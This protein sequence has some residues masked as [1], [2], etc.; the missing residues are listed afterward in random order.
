VYGSGTL[1]R[2]H[3]LAK[4]PVYTILVKNRRVNALLTPKPGSHKVY[5]SIFV[6]EGQVD[7]AQANSLLRDY[8]KMNVRVR[9]SRKK[10]AEAFRGKINDYVYRKGN[11]NLPQTWPLTRK[12]VLHGPWPVLST[13]ACLV[14]LPGVRD[15]NAARAK[16]SEHYLQNCSQILVVAPIKRAVDDGTAKELLGEQFKRRLLM[17]GQ[18]GNVSFICTQ[19]DDCEATET[20]RDHQDVAMKKP[21]R[22]EAMTEIS[23]R[24]GSLDRELADLVQ[25]EEDLKAEWEEATQRA[26]ESEEELEEAKEKA[27]ESLDDNE[28]CVVMDVDLLEGLQI[29]FDQKRADTS[30]AL[31]V[32]DS[33]REGNK[34]KMQKMAE[35][36]REMQRELKAMCAIV[37]NEYSTACLQ[38]D[39][40]A[41]LK[42]LTRRPDEE[43]ADTSDTGS[44]P[45]PDD[46]EMDVYCIS[47]NDHLKIQGIK[48]SSDG[49]PSCFTKPEDT[50][51]P[52][53]R[54]FVHET[55]AKHRVSFTEAFVNDASD[56]LDRVK[57]VAAD[58]K[59][60]PSGRSSRRCKAIFEAE[61]QGLEHK[62]QPVVAEFRRKAQAKVQL[63]LQPLLK[64]GAAKGNAAAMTT[65]MS[66]GSLSRRS[67]QDRRP[68][69]NGLSY[70]TYYAT[71]R[72]NGAYVSKAVGE[73]D[74]NQE[75]CDPM[76]KEFSADW[77]RIMDAAFR[78]YLNECE[79][80]MLAIC[81][82]VDQALVAG[83]SGAGMSSDRLSSMVNAAN[84][85]CS[86]SLKAS[87]QAMQTIAAD[88]QRNLNRSLLPM[89]QERMKDGFA[90][91]VN[92]S[93][94][95]RK[96]KRMKGAMEKHAQ[97]AV[98]SMFS[99]STVELL[100]NVGSL[101]EQ[102]ASMAS[103]TDK[104][105]TRTLESVY[106][107]CWDDES[108]TAAL[109]DLVLQETV[110]ACRD[111][112][113]PDLH[114][115]GETVTGAMQLLGIERDELELDVMG[116]ESWEAQNAKK[117]KEAM[118]KGDVIDLMD[119]D[120]DDM[121]TTKS[122]AVGKPALVS[123]AKK[124]KAEPS[125]PYVRASIYARMPPVT[126]YERFSL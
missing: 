95:P 30:L 48:P 125:N 85:S 41:G 60:I 107:V 101:I 14:D 110:R 108:D 93:G 72:Q 54:T 78:G 26:N 69:K 37:R 44:P 98:Q 9:R 119:S 13:G 86:N 23:D 31:L 64:S 73:I 104:V 81:A 10:W 12:V 24:L 34:E 49:P 21:G 2:C 120:D 55:T 113:L 11:G 76:E 5:N 29:T 126:P 52:A 51:I 46:F 80:Q 88:S 103:A 122:A 17:D 77:Q 99:E 117:L 33:W 56:M 18:Y 40:R 35:Q 96:F 90:A 61:M 82:S 74:M 115:L 71:V 58:T 66:W 70:S 59:D 87:F 102:L 38:E 106:S 53:L 8:G 15:A 28:D 6:S 16:V 45:I 105:I 7:P 112:C 43:D 36:S 22:W 50:Q 94:G 20:M 123:T 39:F 83:F 97:G 111:K 91:T 27:Q 75:L 47:A 32:L 42:E 67:K 100:R 19:T 92:V 4:G 63:S 62:L 124:V 1:E 89:V 3:G 65:V 68:E 116:V 109:M 114:Q 25:E 79:R 57:L 84:R 118:D 121:E